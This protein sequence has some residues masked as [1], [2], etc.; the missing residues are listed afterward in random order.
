MSSIGFCFPYTGKSVCIRDQEQLISTKCDLT[1]QSI[2]P[3]LQLLAFPAM[4][5]GFRL[6]I[7]RQLDRFFL[8]LQC[9]ELAVGFVK[10]LMNRFNPHESKLCIAGIRVLGFLLFVQFGSCPAGT[11][12][13]LTNFR[14]FLHGL[15]QE[16]QKFL[17]YSDRSP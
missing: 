9:I 11:F 5:D 4:K 16:I 13:C 7:Q 1:L 8:F 17:Q 10:L 14:F 6:M 12:S 15:H 2:D 3:F